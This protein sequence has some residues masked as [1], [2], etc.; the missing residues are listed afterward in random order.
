[1]VPS[2]DIKSCSRI[3]PK[4]LEMSVDDVLKRLYEIT[5]LKYI[6]IKIKTDLNKK[7][8]KCK[9]KTARE[10]TSKHPEQTKR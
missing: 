6:Q 7:R 8:E 1:M 3:F 2:S 4:S 10:A 5:F 9:R